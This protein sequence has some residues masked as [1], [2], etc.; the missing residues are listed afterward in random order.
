MNVLVTSSDYLA[1][2]GAV[3]SV[4]LSFRFARLRPEGMLELAIV[5]Q[6]GLGL[7][8]VIFGSKDTWIHVYGHA[9]L[10]SP[11]FVLLALRAL[12]RRTWSDLTPVGLVMPR[13]GLQFASDALRV[14]RGLA[15]AVVG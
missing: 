14:M 7:A 2:V 11:A 12:A 13:I 5:I 4:A 10:L 6:G 1:M 9:R 15:S 8:L 3:T